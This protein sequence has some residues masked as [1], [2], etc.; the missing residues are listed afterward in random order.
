MIVRGRL[1]KG[2]AGWSPDG[3]YWRMCAPTGLRI[4]LSGRKSGVMAQ[5]RE[6]LPVYIVVA[7]RDG[8]TDFVATLRRELE[9]L[10]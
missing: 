3:R 1:V 5:L 10:S 9:Q 7:E 2:E 8:H 4:R 6:L